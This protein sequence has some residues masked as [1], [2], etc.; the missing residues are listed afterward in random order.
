MQVHSER[1]F[2]LFEFVV[3]GKDYASED[4]KHLSGNVNFMS[5]KSCSEDISHNNLIGKC[6]STLK[7]EWIEYVVGI[8]H[9]L[10]NGLI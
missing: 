3:V 8:H 2:L 9:S 6:L 7:I 4:R 1:F 10:N 5:A